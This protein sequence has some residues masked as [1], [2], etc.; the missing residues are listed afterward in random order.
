MAQLELGL[1]QHEVQTG[2]AGI[3]LIG[4]GQGAILAL[5]LATA[6][7]ELVRAVVATDGCDPHLPE[8]FAPDAELLEGLRV[9]LLVSNAGDLARSSRTRARLEGLGAQVDAR[10]QTSSAAECTDAG[11]NVAAWLRM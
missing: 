8:E 5:L 4:R 11:A 7:H 3:A 6:W 10:A 9:L 2:E 1:L